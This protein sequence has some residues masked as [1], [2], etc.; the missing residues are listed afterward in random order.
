ME[1]RKNSEAI[2]GHVR[3]G[4]FEQAV[5][6]SSLCRDIGVDS[7]KS[8]IVTRDER[9]VAFHVHRSLKQLL[10]PGHPTRSMDHFTP[11]LQV[12][13]TSNDV[14]DTLLSIFL[15]QCMV[16]Q[17]NLDNR[18]GHITTEKFK[19]RYKE[20]K[21]NPTSKRDGAKMEMRRREG[22][23]ADDVDAM[24]ENIGVGLTENPISILWPRT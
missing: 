2:T 1:T 17:P 13:S 9:A 6:G 22:A 19:T 21:Q 24:G 20:G 8:R 10:V 16:L 12:P 14:L 11:V 18:R 15:S 23:R 7:R 3:I 5:R 4:C